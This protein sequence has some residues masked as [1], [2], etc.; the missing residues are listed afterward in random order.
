MFPA[1][2][3][4]RCRKNSD[5]FKIHG[6]KLG[7]VS[8]SFICVMHVPNNRSRF[9]KIFW[10]DATHEETIKLSF[11]NIARDPEASASG[12]S[13]M[14]SAIQWV[15]RMES[16]WLLVFDNADGKSNMVY[17]SLPAVNRGNVLITSRNPEMKRNVSPGDWIEV[18]EMEEGDAVTLLLKAAFLDKSS[19][20]MRQASKPIV[21]ELHCLPLAVDQAGAA[22][23]SGLCNVHDY[24][25]KYSKHRQALL[26]HPSFEGAS[27][28][29]RAVYGT[30]DLSFLALEAKVTGGGLDA[31]A[32]KSAIIILETFA[33]FHCDGIAEDI[34]QR[35]AEASQNY[36]NET[37]LPQKTISDSHRQLLN[38]NQNGEWDYLFFREGIQM[39]LSFSLI[40]RHGL[41]G[42]YSI[43]PLVHCWSRDRMSQLEQQRNG[44]SAR[45]LLS[46]S[47][48]FQFASED[49]AFRR[50][51]LPHIKANTRYADEARAVTTFCDNE[52]TKFASVF[53]ENGYWNDAE[54]LQ[55][56][57]MDVRRRVL[58]GEHP[59]TLSSMAS[60]AVTYRKQRKLKDAENLQVEVMDVRR[61]VLGAEHPDI[62]SSMANLA[63]TYRY[64]GRWKE[65]ENLEV[66]V[67]DVRI[68]V[69]GAEHPDTL[70]SM[71][72]LALT[73]SHQRRW[74]EAENL[75]V[76]V[77]DVRK[78]VL[79][80][81][82]PDTLSSMANLA[83]TH[84]YQGRWKEAENL[85]A[86]V[87]GVRKRVFGAEHP[88]TLSS[89]ANLAATYND[90]GRWKEAENLQ[91]DVMDMRKR[92]LGTEHPHTLSGMASLAN[93]YR[94]QKRWKEAKD[95]QVDVI[96]VRKRVLGAEHPDTLLSM[97]SLAKIYRGQGRWDEAENLEDNVMDV[98]RRVLGA[99]HPHTLSSMANLAIT[100]LNQGK[101]KEAENLQVDVMKVGRR[102]FGVEHPHT[103]SS[104]ANL[105]VTYGRQRRWKEA[106][107]LQVDV[108]NVRKRVFVVEHPH[109]LTIMANLAATYWNQGRWKEAEKLKGAVERGFKNMEHP[110]RIWRLK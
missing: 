7:S 54:N 90:Q 25:Q 40:K 107:N 20:E 74:M 33:F 68:R 48:T 15:S 93:T 36:I 92:V 61:R 19:E 6:R 80:A 63:S 21:I 75:Q 34:F 58:G 47:I 64:Q 100:Y 70:S 87:M 109:T 12:V 1:V 3:N 46:Q 53:S 76:N 65:A 9:H 60:L 26:A 103:L 94:K 52:Y 22:I 84:S 104:M 39:L 98:R 78:R 38:C 59:D 95:L 32:A 110:S 72:D 28:Y 79:G 41:Q 88:D 50:I 77:V 66:D 23:A 71:A 2:R 102:V 14:E 29:G 45:V 44:S 31:Q 13:D 11:E 89:M 17:K 91:V 97:A 85:E 43:H 106:E 86:D 108:M 35:A 16:S 49:Y 37:N 5:L 10:I 82:H 27:N 51:I 105:A 99:E 81:E 42:G 8:T 67:M 56:D 69:F 83:V 73:Y 55:V 4:G 96:D 18:E 57:V 62:L 30:W 24:L 101:F